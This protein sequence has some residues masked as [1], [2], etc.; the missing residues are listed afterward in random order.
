MWLQLFIH[1][2]G[3]M[4]VKPVVKLCPVVVCALVLCLSSRAAV[5]AEQLY[6]DAQKA[7][8][9]G[10]TMRAYVLY[11]EAAA[12]EPA[13]LVY[14][15]RA[16]ALR[17]SA[18][19]LN[20]SQSTP[21]EFAPEKI[22][23]TVFG[24]I[25]A[26]D[27]EQ[28]RK[29]LPPPDLKVSAERQDFNL[30]G[31]AKTLWEKLAAAFHF[32]VVFDTQYQPSQNVRF[33]VDSVDSREALRALQAATDSFF[34]P[35]SDR[36]IFVA[37]DTTQKR[38]EFEKTV[39]IVI[40]FPETASVQELQEITVGV[41]GLLDMQKLMIDSQRH[42]ILIKD[43][44][45]KVR[46]AQKLFE[47]LLRPRPQVA[48]EVEIMTTDRTSSLSYG[49]SLQTAFSIM[50]SVTN[51]T[52]PGLVRTF[53]RG[54]LW[55]IGIASASLFATAAKSNSTTLLNSEIVALD[56]MPSTLHVG[57]KYPIVTN[58]YLGATTGTGQVFTPPPTFNFEDL[59]LVLKVT[60]KI[61]GLD[62]VT[63]DINAEVKLLGAGSVDGIPIVSARKFESK[64]RIRTGEWAVLGGLISGS[65]ARTITG[66]PLISSIPLL[67][68][69][70]TNHED[71]ETLIILKPHLL[72]APPT[73]TATW[74]AYAG[75]ETRLPV[76]F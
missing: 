24:N 43:R 61:H 25:T 9:A 69:N 38:T 29:P 3:R 40:P 28:S 64:V 4:S 72:I 55:S 7:E 42:L 50:S 21:A 49:L 51:P 14:W 68:E 34:V 63:L 37:N 10:E 44:V 46:L 73:E 53:S 58:E 30:R 74:R 15:Q 48:V 6:K 66:I 54:N 26:F 5:P 23:R 17:P 19:F 56:G 1:A 60:P 31:D 62:E 75:T 41:R 16:Q 33:R 67:R 45:T 35:I 11:A 2:A 8:R 65:E 47:D 71:S 39:A 20:V 52:L 32:L 12:A 13:N 76:E 22:D 18:S 57:D 70:K 27:L 36:L 59:G